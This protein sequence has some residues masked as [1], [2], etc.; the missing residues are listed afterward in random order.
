MEELESS[1]M[2]RQWWAVKLVRWC[3]DT[4]RLQ[5]GS[6]VFEGAK[7]IVSLLIEEMRLIER[8]VLYGVLDFPWET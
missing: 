4:Q 2:L 8:E 1:K 6:G 5:R 3:V 7:G